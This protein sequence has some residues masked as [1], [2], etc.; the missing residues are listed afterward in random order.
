[1]YCNHCLPCPQ[2]IDIATVHQYY[3]LA[4]NLSEIPATIVGHYQT[5]HAHASDCIE[6]GDCEERCPFDVAVAENMVKAAALFGR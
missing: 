2:Q 1:M 6:C 4:K 5:L 3:D